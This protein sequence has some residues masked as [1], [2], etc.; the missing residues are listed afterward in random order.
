MRSGRGKV[1]SAVIPKAANIVAAQP[2]MGS[3]PSYSVRNLQGR[4]LKTW[5]REGA[6]RIHR[7]IAEIFAGHHRHTPVCGV[8]GVAR[9]LY[10]LRSN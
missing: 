2:F 4:R 6:L 9:C 3:R 8:A 10:K 7:I 5:M 1:A